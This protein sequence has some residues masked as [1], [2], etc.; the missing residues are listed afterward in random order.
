MEGLRKR[1]QPLGQ[2]LKHVAQRPNRRQA[3]G[4]LKRLPKLVVCLEVGVVAVTR[5][6]NN[7]RAAGYLRLLELLHVEESRIAPAWSRVRSDLGGAPR[8]YLFSTCRRLIEQLSS[9]PIAA[10][11]SDAGECVDP[12]WEARTVMPLRAP[13][14][15]R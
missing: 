10:D 12:K 9:A 5:A 13:T 3:R 7:N 6:A 2:L 1:V 11:A 14:M 15:G 4:L 8:L